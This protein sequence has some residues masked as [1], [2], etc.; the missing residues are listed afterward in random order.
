[1]QKKN[2][3]NLIFG[4]NKSYQFVVFEYVTYKVISQY[5]KKVKM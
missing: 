4:L 5:Q 3:V 2:D 1:M